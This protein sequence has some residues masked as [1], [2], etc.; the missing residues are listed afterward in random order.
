M[1]KRSRNDRGAR[2]GKAPTP[3]TINQSMTALLTNILVIYR[4]GADLI[5][6]LALNFQKCSPFEAA[7][8]EP[9][10]HKWMDHIRHN[11]VP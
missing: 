10:A 9:W 5:Q 3:F 1:H 2:I 7:R 6:R 8:I 4:R 11:Y